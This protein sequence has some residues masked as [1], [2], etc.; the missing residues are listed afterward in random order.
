M[1]LITTSIAACSLLAASA[2]A[3]EH[4]TITDL[5]TLGGS[6][7]IAFGVNS[8]GRIGG[9]STLDNQIQH[10]FLWKH[11]HMIDAGALGVGLNAGGSGPNGSDEMAIGAEI[12]QKDPLNEDFCAFGTGLKCVAA[13]WKDGVLT[14]LPTLPDGNSA[15]AVTINA[16]GQLVGWADTATIDKTCVPPQQ[17]RF[18]AVMWG[19]KPSQVHTLPPLPGDTVG[20]AM[21]INDLGQAVGT[22]GDCAST[23]L[24]PFPFG[25]HAVLWDN[26]TPIDLGN[27]GGAGGSTAAAINNRTEVVGGSFFPDGTLHTFLWTRQTGRMVDLGTVKNMPVAAP[28]GINNSG[29]IAGLACDPASNTCLAYVSQ[30]NVLTDLNDLIPA[31]STLYLAS[32]YGINDAGEIAGQAMEKK[33]GEMHA[34]LAVP[35]R[36]GGHSGSLSVAA[37]TVTSPMPLPENVRKLL[38]HGIRGR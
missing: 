29:Q 4:Y 10:P 27:V 18:A 7:S 21:G 12:A 20:L 30:G 38:G 22:S 6:F 28:G 11:G 25:P 3:Q 24:F 33:T 36:D 1:R 16:R 2:M 34:F 14:Q 23:A 5:G 26:G 35:I 9:T 8:A 13:L 32:A 31:D 37:Q 15:I 19:P 17:R